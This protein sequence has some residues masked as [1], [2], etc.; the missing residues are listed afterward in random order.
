M[1]R[2]DDFLQHALDATHTYG[3]PET[4]HTYRDRDGTE[5]HFTP[6]PQTVAVRIRTRRRVTTTYPDGTTAEGWETLAETTA[7][8]EPGTAPGEGTP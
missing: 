3:E 6:T 1:D 5:W 7:S 4:V 2:H 8:Y